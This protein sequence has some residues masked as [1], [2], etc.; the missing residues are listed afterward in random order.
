MSTLITTR[1]STGLR[2]QAAGGQ[3]VLDVFQTITHYLRR[4]LSDAH[5]LMFAEPNSRGLGGDVDW[6]TPLESAGGVAPLSSVQEPQRSAILARLATLVNDVRSRA[7]ELKNSPRQSDRLLG[8]LLQLAIE[9]PG[10]ECL[11]AVGTQP[12]L[13]FWGH[14]RDVPVPES[15]I[16]ERMIARQAGTQPPPPAAPER[17]L[18]VTPGQEMPRPAVARV[19]VAAAAVEAPIRNG[20]LVPT[21]WAVLGVLCIAIGLELLRG[22][23]IGWP[24]VSSASWINFCPNPSNPNTSELADLE[25]QNAQLQSQL[26][27]LLGNVAGRRDQCSISSGLPKAPAPVPEVTPPAPTPPPPPAEPPK[28]DID[29]PK[30]CTGRDCLAALKGCW[31]PDG[32]QY[33]PNYKDKS[34]WEPDVDTYCFKDDSG[35]GRFS[36][37]TPSGVKCIG[38]VTATVPKPGELR[39]EQDQIAQCTN[40]RS[41]QGESYE[42]QRDEQANETRCR[43]IDDPDDQPVLHRKSEPAVPE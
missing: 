15:G 2:A 21:L 14:L 40:Q 18:A 27:Q 42:C 29:I 11:Y 23:G 10:E 39:I 1:S 26:D 36:L 38:P 31:G 24:Y 17:Q 6:Y 13:I 7:G 4:E 41:L 35:A 12:V 25:A 28:V 33:F 37:R 19:P 30:G 9:V 22:C 34:V 8:Q 3:S 20:W 32:S 43:A 5:S 16:I